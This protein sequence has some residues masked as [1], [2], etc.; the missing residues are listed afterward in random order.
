MQADAVIVGG[1]AAGFFAAIQCKAARP[2]ARV[3]ILEKSRKLLAKVR[4]SGGGRCNVTHACFDPRQLTSHY[5]RGHREL[6]GPFHRWNPTHTVD[7]FAA[8]D[9][10]LKTESDGRMFPTTDSSQTIIDALLDEARSLGVDIRTE[11]G[12][13]AA[14]PVDNGFDL[15]CTTGDPIHTRSLM[16]ATGGLHA[17]I[18][19]K[20]AAALGHTISPPVPSLFTFNIKHPLLKDL[21]GLS[22]TPVVARIEGC[23]S[24]VQEG[25]LLITHWGLSGPAILKL[26]AWGARELAD[27]AYDFTVVI[28]WLGP[29][30]PEETASQIASFRTARSKQAIH[31]KSPFP[32]I[33]RRLW[34]R[35]VELAG[36]PS[37]T[38]WA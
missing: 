17:S 15:T 8:R 14:E 22:V 29:Q 4:I 9:V 2:D 35:M 27:R 10:P 23:K 28:N 31:N 33:P 36:I 13:A 21:P 20:T 11:C 7:W 19:M 3:I 26:S 24:L 5:P 34:E 38:P 30:S 25:P 6:L 12:L 1:G 37:G 18:G 16:L 32:P